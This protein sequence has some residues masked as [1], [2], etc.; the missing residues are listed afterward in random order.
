M[1]DAVR[2]NQISAR[3]INLLRAERS[4][5]P[6]LL[7]AILTF[8]V[9]S[10]LSPSVFPITTNIQAMGFQ[11]PEVGLLGL[12]V[13]LSMITAG[14]DLSVV[15]IANL[16][17]VTMGEVYKAIGPS[18]VNGG[19]GMVMLGALIAL[20]AGALCGAVNGLLIGKFGIT[21]ILVT[22]STG[23]LSGGLAVAWTGGTALQQL[24]NELLNIGTQKIVGIPAP[25]IIFVIA[26]VLVALLLN[27][28]K[29]GLKLVLVGANLTAAR[30]SGIRESRSL[31][32]TYVT[33]GLLAA[34]AGI[35]FTA[36]TASVTSTYGSSYVLL[37]VVIAVLG[38]VDPN[39]GFGTV[40]GVVLATFI[41]QMVQS[42]FNVLGFNQFLNQAA[43]GVILIGVLAVNMAAQRWRIRRLGK[44]RQAPPGISPLKTEAALAADPGSAAGN[45]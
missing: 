2:L 32:G 19:W 14:I 41:L 3:L 17:A 23:Y 28:T 39:G 4:P 31:T 5:A 16:A 29:F 7:V 42:G 13:S 43:Q 12:A 1:N 6:L 40:S 35:V 38:G 30:M 36:R 22:L 15:G 33:S 8:C 20:A 9:F 34:T 37:A 44:R 27:W 10:A 21:A 26:A 45:S 25:F 18:S 24:P 11:L